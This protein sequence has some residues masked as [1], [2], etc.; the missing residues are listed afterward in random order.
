VRGLSKRVANRAGHTANVHPYLDAPPP[1]AFAHRG[2]AAIGDENTMTAFARAVDMGYRY[3]EIDVHATADGV[4]VVFHDP[5]LARMLG[6]PQRVRE[7]RWAD[8][9]SIRIGGAAAVPRLDDVLSAWPRERFNVDMKAD[10][11]V[12]PTVDLVR[13]MNATHRVLLASFSDARLARVRRQVGPRLATSTGTREVARLWLASRVG[14]RARRVRVPETVVATQVPVRHGRL[15]VLDARF[16][17]LAH[18]LGL[19]VHAWTID[20]AAEMNELLDLGVDGIM[21]DRIDVLREVYAARGLWA[22]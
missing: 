12:Q 5:T 21:T 17:A 22:D 4:P 7:V 8:L 6:Q 2:G 13:S 20:D 18:R 16:V 1:L 15:R 3:L 14:R 9:E 11:V 10:A 19:Q